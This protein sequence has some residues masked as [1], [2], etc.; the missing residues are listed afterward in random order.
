MKRKYMFIQ[1][2]CKTTPP[3]VHNY[4]FSHYYISFSLRG[5]NLV[6]QILNSFFSPHPHLLGHQSKNMDTTK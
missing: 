2:A 5:I 6:D 3:V 1:K 4:V